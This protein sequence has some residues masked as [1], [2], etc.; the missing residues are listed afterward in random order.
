VAAYVNRR[1]T[2]IHA[3]TSLVVFALATLSINAGTL[4]LLDELHS[5]VR[6]P[7]YSRR[8][9]H[10]K[11][12]V[13]N[14]P[15]R[16]LILVVGSSRT[17]MG[18]RPG[19]WEARRHG[20][21]L[22]H[23]P[24]VFNLSLIGGGPILEL[25][26]LRRALADGLKPATVLLEYWPPLF[27]AEEGLSKNGV[28]FERLSY[29]DRDTINDGSIN[30]ESIWLQVQRNRLNPV[31]SS[32]FRLLSQIFP[33][34]IPTKN[35]IDWM[36]NDVDEWGWKPGCD[37]KPGQSPERAILVNQARDVFR[38]LFSSYRID[39][40][41]ECAIRE[42]VKVVQGS[43]IQVCL[44]YMP[45]SSEFQGWYPPSVERAAKEHLSRLSNELNVPIID[46]R[47]WM[48]DGLFSD[49]FHLTRIGAAEFTQKLV[50]AI[51]DNLK[52]Y[53]VSMNGSHN[54]S[55]SKSR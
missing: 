46:A 14:H 9:S 23:D 7:E 20:A 45:E 8:V 48:D 15:D 37:F 13:T 35:R 47:N 29:R 21:P 42:T 11:S 28:C 25:L 51:T 12:H 18:V 24:L 49:G 27:S 44:L 31:Y 55:C 22:Q 5:G 10:L 3:L 1:H 2:R 4:I 43:G 26:I 16:P 53:S 54:S 52:A 39:P 50:P 36:W 38:R 34:W 41:E 30:S 33:R 6:D 17:A 40:C 19:E 32:R